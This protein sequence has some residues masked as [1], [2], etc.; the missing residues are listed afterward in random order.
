MGPSGVEG[1]SGRRGRGGGTGR[2]PL[3]NWPINPSGRIDN[4]QFVRTHAAGDAIQQ[5]RVEQQSRE[6]GGGWR[7][8]EG[9][10]SLLIGGAR[11]QALLMATIYLNVAII[12]IYGSI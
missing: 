12:M 4:A 11:R 10:G 3:I 6:E 1:W 9:G 2:R 7:V 5:H 8:E